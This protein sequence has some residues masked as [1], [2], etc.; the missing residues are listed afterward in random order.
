M[1]Q[2]QADNKPEPSKSNKKGQNQA[3]KILD[4]FGRN[5][6]L[7]ASLGELDEAIG[8][9]NEIERLIQVLSRRKKNNPV[10]VGEPGT[11]KCIEKYTLVTLRNDITGEEKKISVKDFLTSLSNARL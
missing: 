8:R 1:S 6:T 4:N 7:L 5:L 10:L 11:G 2:E 3:F 9:E